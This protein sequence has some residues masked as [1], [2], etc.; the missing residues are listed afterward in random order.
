MLAQMNKHGGV[1]TLANGGTK[2]QT[3]IV[4]QHPAETKT[5]ATNCF[6]LLAAEHTDHHPPQSTGDTDRQFA[7][8]SASSPDN[9]AG[10]SVE[11][12]RSRT[13]PRMSMDSPRSAEKA[14]NEEVDSRR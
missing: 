10:K 14:K 9:R 13:D 1:K 4:Q 11:Q 5:R 8:P 7:L 12:T 3:P 6:L 2:D